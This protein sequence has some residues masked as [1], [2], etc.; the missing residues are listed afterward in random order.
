MLKIKDNADLKELEKF[1]FDYLPARNKWQ[2]ADNNWYIEIYEEYR[3][4]KCESFDCI[5]YIIG[6]INDL[7]FDLIQTNS[8]TTLSYA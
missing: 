3:K 1:G 8:A 7:L 6:D 2:Y 5:G 4:I